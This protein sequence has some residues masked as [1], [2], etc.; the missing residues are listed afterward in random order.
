MKTL[1]IILASMLSFSA[2]ATCESY[3]D[4]SYSTTVID[5]SVRT[6]NEENGYW[7]SCTPFKKPIKI[8]I[9]TNVKDSI[10]TF[11]EENGYW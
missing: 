6:F 11:N 2:L 1:S 9:D 4:T 10:D 7:D 3:I 5:K 8:L